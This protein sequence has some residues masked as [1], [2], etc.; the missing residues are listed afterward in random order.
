MKPEDCSRM[1]LLLI[2]TMIFPVSP[3]NRYAGIE[4]LVQLISNELNRR[5]YLV[6]VAAPQGSR[7][8]KGIEHINTG[9]CG[10]FIESERKAYWGYS[11]RLRDF[12]AILEMSHS[13]WCMME[14]DLPAI[15]F[16]WHDPMIMKPQEPSYNICAL[17]Q[18]QANRFRQV[19]GYEARV[20]DPH[21]V[22]R[23]PLPAVRK[24]KR[25]LFIGRLNPNKGVREA[26]RICRELSVGLDIIGGLGRGDSRE[27]LDW[28]EANSDRKQIVYQGEVDDNI[29]FG[30]LRSARA[31]IYPINYPRGQGEAHSHK[32]AEA[33]ATGC[34]CISYDVGA[35][36]EVIEHGVTG[37]L[38]QDEHEFKEHMLKVET[39]DRKR[40]RERAM[41]RWSVE[42]TV[43]RI[44]PVLEA[45]AKGERWGNVA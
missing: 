19:Y 15:A 35:F 39:L 5:G 44:I 38:A 10:D 28:V 42:A 27:F 9:P 7:L 36:A 16:I 3:E 18:W 21:C 24:G 33:L 37:F 22:E 30:F 26:V 32:M 41:K 11:H 31:L 34:P 14:N 43:D 20:L 23:P 45:V 17:S 40:V 13:H 6:S 29:K 4:T 1:K 2:S 8:A 12:D 25:F